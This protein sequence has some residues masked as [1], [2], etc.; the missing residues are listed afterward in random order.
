MRAVLLTTAAAL[1][2]VIGLVHS[3]LGE[4]FV[5]RRLFRL[6]DLP[7][8]RNDRTYTERVLRYAWHLTSVAWWGFAALSLSLA[9]FPRDIRLLSLILGGASA[10]S[11]VLILATAG[12]RHPAWALFLVAGALTCFASW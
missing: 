9:F 8:L 7:L 10:V 6:S 5:F 4:R 3:Y 11:G 12:L 2:V 1:L